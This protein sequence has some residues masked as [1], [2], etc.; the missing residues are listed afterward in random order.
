MRRIWFLRTWCE[1]HDQQTVAVPSCPCPSRKPVHPENLVRSSDA[2]TLLSLPK[3]P[4][5]APTRQSPGIR[6]GSVP[7]LLAI[8][9]D[10]LD[11]NFA[12][13]RSEAFAAHRNGCPSRKPRPQLR[14]GNFREDS[15]V[16]SR[17]CS[18]LRATPGTRNF[19]GHRSEAR[20]ARQNASIRLDA[21]GRPLTLRR[22]PA[23]GRSR[24]G[25][26]SNRHATRR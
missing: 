23:F 25:Q 19:A 2:P 13:R 24:S 7:V 20:S 26:R 22:N 5:A 21:H 11:A 8:S 14:R 1:A 18:R 15:G 4:S 12:G 6:S 17:I 10:A 3:I 16:L 9:A